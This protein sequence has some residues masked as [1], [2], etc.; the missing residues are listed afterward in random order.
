MTWT[1]TLDPANNPIDEVR[2]LIGDT[3]VNDQLLQDEELQYY[4]DSY[5]SGVNAAI[6][7][8]KG[9]LALFARFA[10]ERTGEVEVKFH[11]R[12]DSYKTLLDD[13]EDQLL[14]GS[15]PIP[16]AGGIS[17]ADKDS[18]NN[19]TDRV[20]DQF[21]TGMNDNNELKP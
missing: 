2:L 1:Y 13:L 18:R 14:T 11:Q 21:C 10:D 19:D 5:G 9:I 12:V 15:V 8:V 6:P 16:F 17:K 3:D 4:I 7:A 20:E